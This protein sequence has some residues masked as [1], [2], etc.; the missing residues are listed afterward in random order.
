MKSIKTRRIM[1][2]VLLAGILAVPGVQAASP[3]A[4]A[5]KNIRQK[6]VEVVRN[7][8]DLQNILVGGE[9]EVLFTVSEEG[10][11]DIK[12]L[13]GSNKEIEDFVRD[14]ISSIPCNEYIFPFNQHYKV[15]FRFEED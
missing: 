7:P 13:E 11:I 2:I 6:F 4:M 15:K 10:K 5:A 9:V 14:K 1:L 12:R 8:A 3:A